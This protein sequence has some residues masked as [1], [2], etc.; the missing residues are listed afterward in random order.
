MKKPY[1]YRNPTAQERRRQEIAEDV[2]DGAACL[3]FVAVFIGWC[4]VLQ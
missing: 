3:L 4:L 2:A 1:N